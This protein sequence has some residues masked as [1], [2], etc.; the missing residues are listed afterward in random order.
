MITARIRQV[1]SEFGVSVTVPE[2]ERD[3]DAQLQALLDEDHPKTAVFLARGNDLG[4]R[5]LPRWIFV[6]KRDEGTL[7]TDCAATALFFRTIDR[8]TDGDLAAL[9]GYPEAKAEVLASGDCAVVQT[10]DKN[11]CVIFE[12]AAT[13]RRLQEALD[14]AELQVPPGGHTH[15]TSAEAALL[16]RFSGKVN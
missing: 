3:I 5:K 6:E 4:D 15:V 13:R 14:A 1:A 12:V 9:L 11:G 2:L 7:I 8:V 16:R 10:M